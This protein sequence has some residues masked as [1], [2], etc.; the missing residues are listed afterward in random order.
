M[1]RLLPPILVAGL[2]GV[3]ALLH[4]V[5]PGMRLLAWP[6]NLVGLAPLIL[7]F[8][9]AIVGSAHFA[10]VGTNIKTFNRPDRLVTDGAFR[11]T[12]N[13]MYLGLLTGL[14][15]LWLLLGTLTPGL[16]VA[17]FFVAADRWYIPFE[18][19]AM[20][21]VFGDRYAAYAGRVRR[22]L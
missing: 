5:L 15:G 10:R 12:R 6:L 17:V 9:T 20:T 1:Q 16:G 7:G 14:L 3:M 13:P 21:R 22:W 4:L 18:E 8:G 19:R 2:A 11:F